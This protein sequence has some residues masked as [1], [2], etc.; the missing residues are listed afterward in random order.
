MKPAG[1]KLRRTKFYLIWTITSTRRFLDFPL[2]VAF[3]AIGDCV[4]FNQRDLRYNA[5][6][7]AFGAHVH[8]RLGYHFSEAISG[9]RL[10]HSFFLLKKPA[11]RAEEAEYL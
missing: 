6:F 5:L 4:P 9:F 7:L 3:E 8:G 1:T 10:N 11:I 2:D